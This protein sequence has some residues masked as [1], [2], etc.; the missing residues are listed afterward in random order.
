M[1]LFGERL[2]LTDR[3]SE[4]VSESFN[5]EK[6][7]MPGQEV[8]ITP[9]LLLLKQKARERKRSITAILFGA[10]EDPMDIFMRYKKHGFNIEIRR[11]QSFSEA[12]LTVDKN[13]L[14]DED[15]SQ[16]ISGYFYILPIEPGIWTSITFEK[17]IFVE[18]GLMKLLQKHSMSISRT[19]FTSNEIHDVL[20]KIIEKDGMTAEVIKAVT[21]PYGGNGDIDF[22][23]RSLQDLFH[24]CTTDRRYLDKAKIRITRDGH[25]PS[26]IFVSRDGIFRFYKG[27]IDFFFR[28]V[29]N[30]FATPAKRTKKVLEK[31]ER[32]YGNYDSKPIKIEF[33]HEMFKEQGDNDKFV[34]AISKIVKSGVS[35]YH[36]NPYLHISLVDFQDGSTYDIFAVSSRSLCVVPSFRTSLDSLQRISSQMFKN[37]DE[38][39]VKDWEEIERSI[40]D[41]FV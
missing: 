19:G 6:L 17:E 41:Y 10:D 26:D 5:I 15:K 24:Y 25:Q 4:S 38:G 21:Y 1:G 18:K 3:E 32:T 8:G 28:I 23:S 34:R 13:E 22:N 9:L 30:S 12:H 35:V 33:E 40:D 37:F 36:R 11:Y 20:T 39:L 16:A 31:R 7:I 29:L 2:F 27:D 14:A